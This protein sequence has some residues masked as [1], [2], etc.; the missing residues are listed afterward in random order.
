MAFKFYIELKQW[1]IIN[2]VQIKI[3]IITF[4]KIIL[5]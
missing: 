1:N 5:I 4:S 3:Q 2:E